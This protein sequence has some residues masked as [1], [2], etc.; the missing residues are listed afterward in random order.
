[1]DAGRFRRIREPVAVT[2]N[3]ERR[4]FSCAMKRALRTQRLR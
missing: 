2:A 1:M 3:N 4:A